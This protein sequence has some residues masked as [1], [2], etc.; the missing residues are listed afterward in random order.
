MPVAC[1]VEASHRLCHDFKTGPARVSA[2]VRVE[3]VTAHTN[4]DCVVSFQAM[5]DSAAGLGEC[6]FVW[7]GISE[8]KLALVRL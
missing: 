7:S 5:L 1:Y 2:I 8:K 4:V 3:N 6:S